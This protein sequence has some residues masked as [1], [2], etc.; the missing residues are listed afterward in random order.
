MS[1]DLGTA[2]GKIVLDY[3]GDQAV[4]KAESDID[5]LKK[6]ADQGDK[7]VG[8]LGKALG[9]LGKGVSLGAL[10]VGLTNGAAQAGA[11]A[12]QVAGIVPQLV[13]IASL[14]AALPA[15][16]ASAAVAVGVLKASFAGI[17]EVVKEAF[18]TESPEK[19]NEALKKLSPN[20]QAFAIALR[21]Q[22]P[23]LKEIQ[24]GIQD[25]F[26]SNDFQGLLPRLAAGL[27][28]MQP[29]LNGLAK[30]FGALGKSVAG[31]VLDSDAS[32]EFLDNA[33]ISLREQ[34][35]KIAPVIVPLLTGLRDVG[36]VGL[37]LMDRLGSAVAEVAGEFA[38]WLSEIAAD[39]RLQGWIDTALS[40]LNELGDVIGNVFS[41]L[42]SVLGAAQATGGGLLG[43]LAEI[44][45]QFAAFLKSAEGSAA[46]NAL[47]SS[48]LEIARQLAPVITTLVGALAGAL[49]PALLRIATEIGPVLLETVEALAP[50]FAPLANA[51]A[52]LLIAVAPLIPPIAKLVALLATALAGGVSGLASALGPVISMLSGGMLQALEELAPLVSEVL[53][54]ALPIAA[55]AGLELAKAFAPLVPAIV[56]FASALAQALLPHIP[57]LI[58]AA[59]RL[60]PP[61]VELATLFADQLA[62]G[63]IAI[64]PHLPAII[65]FLVSMQSAIITL[66][67]IGIK[68]IIFLNNLNQKFLALP[69]AIAGAMAGLREGVG[70]ALGAV[71]GFLTSLGGQIISWFQTLPGRIIGFLKSLPGNLADI[72]ETAL[73][74]AATIVGTIVGL[75]VGIVTKL[76]PRIGEALANLGSTLWARVTDAWNGARTRFSTG[77]SNATAA[78]RLLPGRVAS[79]VSALPGQLANVARNAWNRLV[80]AFNDGRNRAV[81]NARELTG[82]IRSALGNIGSALYSAGANLIQ[83]LINGISSGIGRVLNMVSG[84]ASRVKGAFNSAL[85]IF[86]PSRVFF[87]SGVNIDEGL[88]N[89]I[90]AKLANVKRMA[91]TLADTVI[92]PTV[93]LPAGAAGALSVGMNT[94][95]SRTAVE[96]A[97][98]SR[99]FG[100]Y[101]LIL[102]G[103]EIA[104]FVIDTLT[105]N[106]TVVSKAANEGSRVKSWS[107]SGRVGVA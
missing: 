56:G 39:G 21:E 93:T 33:A 20:A 30:D 74:G 97:A 3:N 29:T 78:A 62:A 37:P 83:G 68:L 107:G 106:P 73:N 49:G 88:I 17:G 67:G 54:Q 92:S 38:T 52:D 44:T 104:S 61:L 1:Y 14:S 41:I 72:F 71:L 46:I 69:G 43:T 31:F 75:I 6:K 84:L 77:V 5:R 19:F 24:Q 11:L 34:L 86:S 53:I 105:G 28:S 98:D 50:A 82:R 2:H 94:Q 23:A 70:N 87:D 80:S 22:A 13:S 58:D 10:V 60:I 85:Q 100:P 47:F 7:S 57:T 96:N 35:A 65:G 99:T 32:W 95:P 48:I 36:T 90:K 76:P 81:A 4:G 9:A 55:E 15:V 59:Q 45:G 101:P 25:A 79:A 66:V 26:F 12:I 63:L 103:R 42:N 8:K 89:G 16:Y 91:I 27:K 51:I 40:T 102:D 64:I 18:N